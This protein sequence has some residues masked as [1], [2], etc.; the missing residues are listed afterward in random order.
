MRGIIQTMAATAIPMGPDPNSFSENPNMEYSVTVGAWLEEPPKSSLSMSSN[1]VK[2][3][4]SGYTNVTKKREEK[5]K[6]EK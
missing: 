4:F 5:S 3:A 2:I 1:V 6:P